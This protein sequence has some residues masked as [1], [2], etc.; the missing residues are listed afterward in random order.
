MKRSIFIAENF[1]NTLFEY[2]VK[3]K[4]VIKHTVNF[5]FGNYFTIV[6]DPLKRCVYY[7]MDKKIVRIDPISLTIS[8]KLPRSTHNRS[9]H[10]ACW[11]G[12]QSIVVTGGHH[13]KDKCELFDTHKNEWKQLPNLN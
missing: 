6:Q 2:N 4:A 5:K 12:G 1:S 11:I 3:A 8:D 7:I 9:Y 10:S 13:S